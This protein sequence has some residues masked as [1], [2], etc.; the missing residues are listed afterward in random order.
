MPDR[1]VV[2][3]RR[4]EPG[5]VKTRLAPRYGP[6]SA[7]AIYDACLRDVLARASG[8]L[9]D[10][11]ALEI[12]HE[13]GPG[14]AEWF[15]TEFPG[16]CLRSQRG[17]GLGSRLTAAFTVCFGDG[18]ERV[19]IIGSDAPSLPERAL[20]E[21][22]GVRQGEVRIG[23]AEDGGYYLVALGAADW[24]AAMAIFRDIQWSGERVLRQTLERVRG[25]GLVPR[26][27]PIWYDVDRPGD[28]ARA[29]DD[30]GP[31]SH[32]ARCLRE[33]QHGVR[34]RGPRARGSSSCS[35][36]RGL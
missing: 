31:E 12:H 19:A 26:L 22:L 25:L 10:T 14:A 18:A 11:V 30:L 29:R 32:L 17:E 7:A 27:L 21:G 20:L 13:D 24:P 6:A 35:S 15:A 16:T 8:A 36:P 5:R 3:A 9:P 23:P 4:P 34:S 33:P 28:V 2:F 1:L